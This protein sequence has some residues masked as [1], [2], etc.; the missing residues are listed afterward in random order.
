MGV[1]S[2]NF[3]RVAIRPAVAS[4]H[5]EHFY[6]RV[7]ITKPTYEADAG[8]LRPQPIKKAGSLSVELAEA[9]KVRVKTEGAAVRHYEAGERPSIRFKGK[10]AIEDIAETDI[11]PEAYEAEHRFAAGD[12]TFPGS[13][14]SDDVEP[15][16]EEVVVVSES[17]AETEEVDDEA[18]DEESA[19]GEPVTLSRGGIAVE[20]LK[21]RSPMRKIAKAKAQSLPILHNPDGVIGMQRARVS[22]RNP[23]SGTLMVSAHTTTK[24]GIP[25]PVIISVVAIASVVLAVVIVGFEGQVSTEAGSA[26]EAY[27][28]TFKEIVELVKTR[29]T[30]LLVHSL[31]Q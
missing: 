18:D 11:I 17:A 4:K 20:H 2:G 22:D 14:A 27:S 19:A 15:E 21:G 5:A 10:L 3:S 29:I 26:I 31:G 1:D 25:A 12:S 7:P 23:T 16:A 13:V 8:D 6:R 24:R 9:E 30:A 28:F